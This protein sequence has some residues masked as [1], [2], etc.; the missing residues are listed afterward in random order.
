MAKVV[1]AR[2]ISHNIQCIIS[3]AKQRIILVT[4]YLK[5][6]EPLYE[7]LVQADRNKVEITIVYGKQELHKKQE[8]QL[9]ELS[10]CR[11][12]FSKDL[13]AK[14]YLNES[15]GVIGSMNLYDFSEL[16]NKE[17]GV[18]F[19]RESDYEIFIQTQ[20]EVDLII[21]SAK[22]VKDT[23]EIEEEKEEKRV[24]KKIISAS[25]KEDNDFCIKD[26]P[27]KDID[28]SVQYGFATYTL[29]RKISQLKTVREKVC[30]HFFDSLSDEYRV[31]WEKPFNKISIY[32]KKKSPFSSD[33]IEEEYKTEAIKKA[34]K[35]IK[36]YIK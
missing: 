29:D 10:N 14:V 33:T 26:Y 27:V 35:L 32:Q 36:E 13:H 25:Q 22:I 30:N 24:I 34:N 2:G 7:R 9:R 17:M 11:L 15:L 31:Y 18:S 4:P 23:K 8:S 3:E 16:N 12:L 21:D 5:I 19:S 6:A 28:V 20:D 1:T